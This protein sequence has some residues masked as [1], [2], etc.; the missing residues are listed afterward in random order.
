MNENKELKV[1]VILNGI[2]NCIHAGDPNTFDKN[3][4]GEYAKDGYTIKTIYLEEFQ[5]L[6]WYNES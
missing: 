5:K 2:G 1:L 6:K 4:L 3:I